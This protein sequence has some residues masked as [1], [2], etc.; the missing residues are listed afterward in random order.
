MP[1]L[2][3]ADMIMALRSAG[4]RIPVIMISGSLEHSPLPAAVVREISIA[5][6][7]PARPAE[8]LAAVAHVLKAHSTAER[9]R[10]VFDE[11]MPSMRG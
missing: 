11:P 4:S 9:Q 6:V 7:K 2:D 8:I 10:M 3:G 1:V 5:L